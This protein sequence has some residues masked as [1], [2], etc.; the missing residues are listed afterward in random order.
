MEICRVPTY[1]FTLLHHE[2]GRILIFTHMRSHELGVTFLFTKKL[3]QKIGRIP[4]PLTYLKR[5]FIS[6]EKSLN[7]FIFNRCIMWM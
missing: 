7:Y 5:I 4:Y 2:M 3:S 6:V 1:N